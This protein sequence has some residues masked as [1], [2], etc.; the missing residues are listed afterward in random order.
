MDVTEFILTGDGAYIVDPNIQQRVVHGDH[1][2]HF[3]TR[4]QTNLG[5][6]QNDFA[7]HGKM[8]EL[9]DVERQ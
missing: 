9:I 4:C 7:D 6:I 8:P 1:Q 5:Y 2:N 3:Y